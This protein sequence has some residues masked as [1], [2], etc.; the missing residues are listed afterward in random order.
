IR[1][2]GAAR[3]M[4]VLVGL[5]ERLTPG[6]LGNTMAIYQGGERLGIYRKTMLT[7]G[8]AREMGF[9]RDYDLPVFEAKGVTF[10][11]IVCHDSSFVE[12][13][14]VMAYQGAQILFSPHYNSLPADV[15]DE[16]RIKV[17]NNHIG[18]AA[19]LGVYVVRAN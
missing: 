10:G 6:E 3:E 18:L 8:D 13:A 14:A 2:A 9:C 16:H 12:P 11:C 1:L 15:M 7:G 5:V 19:L 4:V 17:R